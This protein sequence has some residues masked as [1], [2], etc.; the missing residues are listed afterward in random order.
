ME[1]SGIP[2]GNQI[3]FGKTWYTDT[4]NE[5]WLPCHMI[6]KMAE[7]KQKRVRTNSDQIKAHLEKYVL[8]PSCGEKCWYQ[9]STHFQNDIRMRINNSFWSLN[10]KERRLWLDSHI[11]I[12]QVQRR[13]IQNLAPRKLNTMNYF[14][15]TDLGEKKQVCKCMFMHTLGMKSDGIITEFLRIKR[16]VQPIAPTQDFRGRSAPP[17]KCND[18]LIRAHINSYN[19]QVSHYTREHAPNRRYIEAGLTIRSK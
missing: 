19:P 17:N 13:F 8:L 7:P 15:P 16:K 3:Y 6:C 1:N 2:Q 10:F 14:L 18:E 11:A 12:K 4:T 9:C 5:T